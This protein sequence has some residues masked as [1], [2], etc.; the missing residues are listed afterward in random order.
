GAATRGGESL[1]ARSH[2]AAGDLAALPAGAGGP[3]VLYA[4]AGR[5]GDGP[6][7]GRTSRS[8]PGATRDGRG[9]APG[10]DIAARA[11]GSADP[12]VKRGRGHGPPAPWRVGGGEDPRHRHGG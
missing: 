12:A 5:G 9:R 1:S 10:T 6:P 8:R 2:R 4:G 3:G 11:R 7:P